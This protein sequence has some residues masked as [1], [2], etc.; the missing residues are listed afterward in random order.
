MKK[1]LSE[2]PLWTSAFVFVVLF[3]IVVLLSTVVFTSWA[4]HLK[5]G[6]VLL[7]IWF[8]YRL[9]GKT[10]LELGLTSRQFYLLPIGL[11]IGIVYFCLLFGMQM[12]QNN[13]SIQFN[14]NIHWGLFFNGLWFLLG[15]VLIEE[16]IFR[17]YCFKK[18][19]EQIGVVKANLIFAF[20][21]IVYHWF[22]LNAW[23]NWVAMLGLITTA[24]GHI[25]FA[26]AFIQSRTL[27]LPIGIHLGNNWAQRHFF[28]VKNMGIGD[29][30][31]L[32]D[33]LFSI[34]V[35]EQQASTGQVIG[36]YLITFVCF[37]ISTYLVWKWYNRNTP[38][39]ISHIFKQ[40]Q[41]S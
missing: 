25:L 29:T 41:S 40:F 31:T 21:F 1:F 36:S 7:T 32:N 34:T 26:T 27:F 39:S 6:V 22:A 16:F 20:L 13:I 35:A 23:G 30:T 28:A 18:T 14:Q 12:L 10:L 17:G 4:N 37:L 33:S 9:E 3:S 8:L 19:Y 15:S 11:G 38:L 5:A 24:F 2:K